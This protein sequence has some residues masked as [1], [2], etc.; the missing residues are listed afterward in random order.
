M[1]KM[2][3]I[4]L[5]ATTGAVC[6]DIEP[7][8]ESEAIAV[9][10]RFRTALLQNNCDALS[11]LCAFPIND[12][13]GLHD[14]LT[15]PLPDSMKTRFGDTGEYVIY[16]DL[17]RTSCS[18]LQTPELEAMRVAQFGFEK[19]GGEVVLEGCGYTSYMTAPN[20]DFSFHWSVG[21]VH[22]IEDPIGEYSL[23]FAF[24]WTEGG[25]RLHHVFGVG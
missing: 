23:V 4:S 3:F 21:C 12:G 20:E 2:I 14:L 24:K 16:I 13:A 5:I 1:L 7:D 8:Y 9:M 19:E 15:S 17:L 18:L 6:I 22:L 10:E 11:E 25:Y